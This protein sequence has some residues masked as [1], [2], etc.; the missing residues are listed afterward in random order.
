M[1]GGSSLTLV[2]WSS[3]PQPQNAPH[4]QGGA[5]PALQHLQS[6]LGRPEVS[7]PDQHFPWEQIECP[8]EHLLSTCAMLSP[9]NMEPQHLELL[10]SVLAIEGQLPRLSLKPG[11][12]HIKTPLCPHQLHITV[13]QSA[14]GTCT[15]MYKKEIQADFPNCRTQKCEQCDRSFVQMTAYY[16]HMANH[17]NSKFVV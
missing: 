1:R 9:L 2:Y 12:Q 16:L 11:Q 7:H 4:Q 8:L 15:I 3:P 6:Y 17:T 14:P 5:A 13:H 10:T